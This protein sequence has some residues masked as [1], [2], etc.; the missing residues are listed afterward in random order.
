MLNT[1]SSVPPTFPPSSFYRPTAFRSSRCGLK[2]ICYVTAA[3]AAL[4]LFSLMQ[5]RNSL[6]Q[7]SRKRAQRSSSS[8]SNRQTLRRDFELDATVGGMGRGGGGG[9]EGT[10]REE[11]EFALSIT[12]HGAIN[13]RRR[14]CFLCRSIFAICRRRAAQATVHTITHSGLELARLGNGTGDP[15]SYHLL[16][17]VRRGMIFL[18]FP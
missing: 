9:E 16:Q 13:F 2:H 4:C 10:D 18:C 8:L 7:Q 12:V 11:T 17:F 6:V 1:P 14:Y 5:T 3:A 15:L